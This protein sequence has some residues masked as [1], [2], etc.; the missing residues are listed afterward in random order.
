MN[1]VCLSE[2]GTDMDE[3]TK[4]QQKYIS[5]GDKGEVRFWFEEKS[6]RW[7]STSNSDSNDSELKWLCWGRPIWYFQRSDCMSIGVSLDLDSGVF[8][9]HPLCLSLSHNA[10]IKRLKRINAVITFCQK[11]WLDLWCQDKPILN[12]LNKVHPEWLCLT[13]PMNSVDRGLL[14]TLT[15]NSTFWVVWKVVSKSMIRRRM[16]GWYSDKTVVDWEDWWDYQSR[17]REI[18]PSFFVCTSPISSPPG[19]SQSSDSS[20]LSS[21]SIINARNSSLALLIT[22]KSFRASAL[23]HSR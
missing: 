12:D 6:V 15:D 4:A 5:S 20:I 17:L 21:T 16:A 23:Q 22:A 13:S 7:I 3:W 8:R 19:K 11:I 18:C 2:K 10:A 1:G 14:S 9:T